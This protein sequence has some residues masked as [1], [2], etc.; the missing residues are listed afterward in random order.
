ML[1]SKKQGKFVVRDGKVVE[2]EAE[3]RTSVDFSNWH[4]GNADP[5]DLR[6]HKE[7]LDRQHFGGPMWAGKKKP[8]SIMEEANEPGFKIPEGER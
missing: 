2:G 5:E 7:L 4:A 3:K 6:R 1:A 8:K